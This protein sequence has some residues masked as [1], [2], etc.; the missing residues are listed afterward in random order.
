MKRLAT[1]LTGFAL[2]LG[3]CAPA[4]SGSLG[5]APTAAPTG[6][7][8]SGLSPAPATTTP[9]APSAGGSAPAT[10]TIT[11]Q[12]WFTRGGTIVP[13]RRIRPATLA[14]SRLSLTELVA[15]PNAVESA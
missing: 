15:G 11:I 5:A 8:S 4:R 12:V 1:L 2:L 14:T 7:A 10:D 9:S 6:S 3:A 13:T